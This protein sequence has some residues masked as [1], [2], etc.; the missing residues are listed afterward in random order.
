MA[1]RGSDSV[2]RA[3]GAGLF[4]PLNRRS[5][6]RLPRPH[7]WSWTQP[8]AK[9]SKSVMVRCGWHRCTIDIR[10]NFFSGQ[11]YTK[12][13]FSRLFPAIIVHGT[14][15]RWLIAPADNFQQH[16]LVARQKP[17]LVDVNIALSHRPCSQASRLHMPRR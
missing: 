3:R 15:A 1:D 11:S 9:P 17:D 14:C 5:P 6:W 10:E 12:H 13:H 2:R 7:F 8:K 4:K 16:F